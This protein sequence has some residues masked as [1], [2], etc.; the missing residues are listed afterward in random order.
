MI[1]TVLATAN[2]P[3]V[4]ALSGVGGTMG[5]TLVAVGAAA[6]VVSGSIWALARGWGVLKE[7]VD[8]GM[9]GGYGG[10]SYPECHC[11]G[12]SWCNTCRAASDDEAGWG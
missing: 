1:A 7:F 9:G 2:G 5:E 10:R 4:D 8:G 3:V 12:D 11:S 6:I